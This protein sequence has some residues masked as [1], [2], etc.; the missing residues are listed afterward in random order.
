MNFA[1]NW[2]RIFVVITF[3]SFGE[4]QIIGG[5]IPILIA[6]TLFVGAISYFAVIAKIAEMFN[7]KKN[8]YLNLLR[9]KKKEHETI[10]TQAW[11]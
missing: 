4:S 3:L 10:P 2:A 5:I 8:K 6:L 1:D 9:V 7:W 11:K